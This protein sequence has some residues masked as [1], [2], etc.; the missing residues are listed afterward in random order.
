MFTDAG[1]FPI[2]V[3]LIMV[4]YAGH[5]AFPTIY[6]SLRN[7][8]SFPKVLTGAYVF[9]GIFNTVIAVCGY[10]FLTYKCSSRT[11]VP[12]GGGIC[13]SS[14]WYELYSSK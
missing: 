3:G 7:K 8:K 11:E 1:E 13:S 12:L 10:V 9:V 14:S 6:T 2:S 4:G 5:A